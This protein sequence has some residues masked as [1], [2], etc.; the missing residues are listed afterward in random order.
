MDF[1]RKWED[2]SIHNLLSEIGKRN[3]RIRWLKGIYKEL[4]SQFYFLA[5]QSEMQ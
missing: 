4:V 1:Q 3:S 5:V 2:S